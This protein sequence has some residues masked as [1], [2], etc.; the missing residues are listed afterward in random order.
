MEVLAAAAP[1]AAEAFANLRKA[2]TEGPL[3]SQTIELIATAALAAQGK[4]D[5]V[6]VHVRRLLSEGASPEAIRQAILA[7]LGAATLFSDAVAA[8]RAVDELVA[9]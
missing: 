1:S 9:E 4:V 6:R 8:L 2:V 7:P 3:D 5:S